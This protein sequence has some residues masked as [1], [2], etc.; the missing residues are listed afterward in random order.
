MKI[1]KYLFV[2]IF[3]SLINNVS[4]GTSPTKF[5]SQNID[6]YTYEDGW[7]EQ[8]YVSTYTYN[9]GWN[10]GNRMGS[11]GVRRDTAVVN[12]STAPVN[13]QASDKTLMFCTVGSTYAAYDIL[14]ATSSATCVSG[15]AFLLNNG[16]FPFTD[17][18]N[19]GFWMAIDK[20]GAVFYGAP[21]YLMRWYRY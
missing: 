6:N 7:N 2:L 16:N 15:S 3:L 8:I 5:S 13:V 10:W 14:F 21:V 9:G 1:S 17:P 19:K 18:S 12:I 20:A 4:A 11:L